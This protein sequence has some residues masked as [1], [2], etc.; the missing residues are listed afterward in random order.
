[1]TLFNYDTAREEK[2]FSYRVLSSV[3]LMLHAAGISLHEFNTDPSAGIEVYSPRTYDKVREMFND[4]LTP[5]GMST[6]PVSYG[7]LCSLG[8]ELVFPEGVGEVNYVHQH[9]S[10]DEW[11]RILQKDIEMSDTGRF[12]L[13]YR[14]KLMEAYPGKHTGWSMGYEGPITSAYE[15]RDMDIFYDFYDHPVKLKEFLHAL[16]ANILQYVKI[17][18]KINGVPYQSQ[19]AGL[20]DDIAA[21]VPP[22]LWEEY[23]VPYWDEYYSPQTSFKRFLHCEDMTREHMGFLEKAGITFFDPSISAKLTPEIIRENSR[24]PFTWRLGDFHYPDLSET[25][26]EDWVFR[27]VED[28]ASEVHTFATNLHADR[29]NIAKVT[30]FYNAAREAKKLLESGYTRKQIGEMVSAEGRKRFFSRWPG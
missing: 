16:T 24:V 3:P 18:R 22:P 11:I 7:H 20:C 13:E 28:G 8:F 21:Q 14:E 25:D 30:A 23:V 29:H 10:L 9:R 6:P 15:L 4:I 19:D 26:I 1:M 5:V 2:G 17:H 12:F 27:A